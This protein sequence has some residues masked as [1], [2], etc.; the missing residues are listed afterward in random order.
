[1]V[2]HVYSEHALTKGDQPVSA[3]RVSCA[4][5]NPPFV[6]ESKKPLDPEV[7]EELR[8]RLER[9]RSIRAQNAYDKAIKDPVK[10]RFAAGVYRTA[11]ANGLVDEAGNVVA[12]ETVAGE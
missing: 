3:C 11:R 9:G 8:R 5:R 4:G 6:M 7:L 2:Y 10:L 12:D 1:M